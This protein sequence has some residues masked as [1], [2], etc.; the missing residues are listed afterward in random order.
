MEIE[1]DFA[2]AAYGFETPLLRF[3]TPLQLKREDIIFILYFCWRRV[4]EDEFHDIIYGQ[5]YYLAYRQFHGALR[6]YHATKIFIHF[7]MMIIHEGVMRL[8][9]VAALIAFEYHCR[10]YGIGRRRHRAHI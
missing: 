4:D 10:L 3:R 6:V 9:T 5:P 7:K 1:A 8:S 2:L